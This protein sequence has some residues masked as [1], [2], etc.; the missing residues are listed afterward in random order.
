M[1]NN[2]PLNY[3]SK[4]CNYFTREYFS[5]QFKYNEINLISNYLLN[6]YL[7]NIQGKLQRKKRK[8]Q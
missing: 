3:V 7:I 4:N 2:F 1:K 6:F 8:K 5:S